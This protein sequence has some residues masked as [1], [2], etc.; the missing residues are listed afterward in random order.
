ML[1]PAAFATEVVVVQGAASQVHRE[2]EEGIN[3]VIKE[4]TV[5]ATIGD[6]PSAYRRRPKLYIAIGPEALDAVK[7]LGVPVVFAMILNPHTLKLDGR[8]IT[9]I[10]LYIS[11]EEQLTNLSAVLP[12]AKRV[13]I[14]YAPQ[15]TGSLVKLI[16]EA[17]AARGLTIVSRPVRSPDDAIL[18]LNAMTGIDVFWMLPDPTVVTSE[19]VKHLLLWSLERKVPVFALSEKYVKNGA[20][21]ALGVDPLSLGRQIG[22]LANRVLAGENTSSIPVEPIKNGT[23]YINA[24]VAERLGLKLPKSILD[25]AVLIEGRQ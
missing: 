11:V 24:V 2:I 15:S 23:L 10:E 7:D 13:G 14:I 6:V 9:G 18:A 21:C 20:L 8:P 5:A 12:K 22:V 19:M 3:S 17:A 25:K 1:A 4:R 16:K